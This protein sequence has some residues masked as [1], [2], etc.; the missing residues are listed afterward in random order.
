MMDKWGKKDMTC[1]RICWNSLLINDK[2][3]STFH[4][5]IR[6]TREAQEDGAAQW[7][8][9]VEPQKKTSKNQQKLL[10]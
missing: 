6:T 2:A 10:F 8:E 3:G 1:E 7:S 4:Y 5:Y 9:Q